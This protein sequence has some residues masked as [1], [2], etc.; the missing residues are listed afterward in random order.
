MEPL[1]PFSMAEKGLFKRRMQEFFLTL[2]ENFPSLES[3][4]R[5][6]RRVKPKGQKLNFVDKNNS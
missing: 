4:S 3:A 6:V 5:G 2:G 1:R